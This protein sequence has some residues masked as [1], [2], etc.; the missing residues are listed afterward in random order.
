MNR[1]LLSFSVLSLLGGAVSGFNV[2][3]ATAITSGGLNYTVIENAQYP[4][5][6]VSSLEDTSVKEIVIP[7]EI[8]YEGT[9]YAV[10]TI[11]ASAFRNTPITSVTIPPGVTRINNQAFSGCTELSEVVIEDSGETLVLGNDYSYSG[12][13]DHAQ[14]RGLFYGAPLTKVYIGRNMLYPADN[15]DGYSPFGRTSVRK[16]SVGPL[17]TSLGRNLF[18]GCLSLEA[19]D[20]AADSHL[21]FIDSDAL[22]NTSLTSLVLPDSVEEIN[23]DFRICKSLKKLHLGSNLRTIPF[24]MF[25]FQSLDSITVSPD[26]K[27]FASYDGAVYSKDMRKLHRV[28]S[29]RE[30][31]SLYPAEEVGDY[32]FRGC[33]N[34]KSLVL[35]DGTVSIGNFA[36]AECTALST[37]LLPES[38]VSVHDT[39]LGALAKQSESWFSDEDWRVHAVPDGYIILKSETPPAVVQGSLEGRESWTLWVPEGTIK[40]YEAT[41]WNVMSAMI[42]GPGRVS[43][44][45]DIAGAGVVSGSGNYEAGDSVAVSVASVDDRLYKFNGWYNGDIHISSSE[46]YGFMMLRPDY[47]L[48]ACFEPIPD[49]A[50]DLISVRIIDGHL[51]IDIKEVENATVYETSI[52]DQSGE[53]IMTV[54]SEVIFNQMPKRAV[55]VGDRIEQNGTYVYHA[56]I[57]GADGSVL[58]HYTGSFTGA[59]TGSMNAEVGSDGLHHTPRVY[60]IEGYPV[61]KPS[62]S[63]I[64][65]IDGKKVLFK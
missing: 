52:H 63:G 49:A 61:D 54:R 12:D 20:F 37:I 56:R 58:A 25:R 21:R 29:N 13:S 57:Y 64:Y 62:S 10:T 15:S 11:A 48:T 33:S 7:D 16:V 39:A 59:T 47:N 28:P 23:G 17:V 27:S 18:W 14:G 30:S 5:L 24:G 45:S 53:K 2:S 34:L 42:E 31:I 43:V 6:S 55:S 46:I 8:E 65:I 38:V 44:S 4:S 32:A 1:L 41:P 50:A 35:P 36:V 22:S 3:A 19:I 9:V 60:T 51:L 26:N 40:S